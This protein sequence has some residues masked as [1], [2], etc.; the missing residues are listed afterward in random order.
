MTRDGAGRG[1]AGTARAV[2]V[3]VAVTFGVSWSIWGAMLAAGL[4]VVP[5]GTVSHLPALV[6]P[7]LGAVAASALSGE[8][9][10][11]A[12]LLRS[13]V[14]WPRRPVL[15]LLLVLAP[16]AVSLVTLMAG[17]WP[18]A[19]AFLAYPGVPPGWPALAGILFV[20]LLNGFGEEAG[21]RGFLLPALLPRLGAFRATL[22]VAAVWML[23]HL[24]LFWLNAAMAGLVG[25][26][27][28]G[29]MVG[30]LLGAFALTHL[31]LLSG[32][33]IL[34][35]AVWHVAY[36]YAVATDATRGL[37]AA[38]TSTAVMAWGLL[39]AVALLRRARTRSARRRTAQGP[40]PISSPP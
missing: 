33:S 17:P 39:V 6:G 34:A 36:D 7:F 1:A 5:G 11:V 37:P 31:W 40:A 3:F 4:R 23:W 18:A 9:P 15:V 10:R 22:V 29:W 24:P 12:R 16:L 27:L 14:A 28:L 30:L 19:G 35:L 38:V 26:V 8:R 20:L 25:P 13:L 21:W 2:A 32:G